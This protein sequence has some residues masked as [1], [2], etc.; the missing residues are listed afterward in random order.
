[1]RLVLGDMAIGLLVLSGRRYLRS[2]Q[3]VIVVRCKDGRLHTDVKIELAQLLAMLVVGEPVASLCLEGYG[4]GARKV[5]S[6]GKREVPNDAPGGDDGHLAGS[7]W[8]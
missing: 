7:I 4:G 1:M 6:R 3:I 8:A 5:G 2:E